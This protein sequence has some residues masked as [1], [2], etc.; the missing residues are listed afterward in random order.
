MTTIRAVTEEDLPAADQAQLKAC[1]LQWKASGQQNPIIP[2]DVDVD[3]DGIVDGYGL[4]PFGDLVYVTGAQLKDTTYE[5][6]GSGIEGLDT[7][8]PEGVS[9]DG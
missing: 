7:E 6:D 3:G 9:T 4:G 8:W 5:A 2:T 1:L